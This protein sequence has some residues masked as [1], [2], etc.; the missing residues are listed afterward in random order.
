MLAQSGAR[1]GIRPVSIDLFADREPAFARY[2]ARPSTPRTSGSSGKAFCGPSRLAPAGHGYALVYGSGLDADSGFRRT[3]AGAEA[4]RQSSEILRLLK[5]LMRF[6]HAAARYSYRNPAA[7]A[8]PEKWL[9]NRSQRGERAHC[10]RAEPDSNAYYQRR[11]PGKALSLVLAN[12]GA[13]IVGF[14]TLC[15]VDHLWAAVLVR[16]RRQPAD[17]RPNSG[18][19]CAGRRAAWP[20]RL[21]SG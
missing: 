1:A 5:R 21:R 20:E 4:V 7:Y 11:L 18:G 14:N 8:D 15:T 12:G 3:R 6:R 13:R 19:K 2:I 16:W 17:L 10:S 9:P